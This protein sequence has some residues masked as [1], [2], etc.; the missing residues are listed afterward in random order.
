[1]IVLNA[2]ASLS[3]WRY[4]SASEFDYFGP[5]GSVQ[6]EGGRTGA[7]RGGCSFFSS[8]FACLFCLFLWISVLLVCLL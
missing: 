8:F 7:G 3:L 6:E 4:V 5:K 2:I 1:M